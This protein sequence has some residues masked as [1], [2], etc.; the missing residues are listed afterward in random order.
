MELSR[1]LCVSR[2]CRVLRLCVQGAWTGRLNDLAG[3]REDIGLIGPRRKI[4]ELSYADF[5]GS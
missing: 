4:G 1:G 3:V 5:D 2:C